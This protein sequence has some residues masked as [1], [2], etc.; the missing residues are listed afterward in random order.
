MNVE[1]LHGSREMDKEKHK[2]INLDGQETHKRK[3]DLYHQGNSYTCALGA[4]H[5]GILG[6][7]YL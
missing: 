5:I 3:V 6:Y 4:M 7:H 1:K 2:R